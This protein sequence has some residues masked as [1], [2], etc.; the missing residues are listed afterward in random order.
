MGDMSNLAE[1]LQEQVW[2]VAEDVATWMVDDHDDVFEE[3]A[4]SVL[5][6]MYLYN[7][8]GELAELQLLISYGGPNI[9]M[10]L[11]P[12]GRCTVKGYWGGERAV[13]ICTHEPDLFDY[14]AAAAPHQP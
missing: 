13:A 6:A 14:F 12:D 1:Q 9:W 2:S 8:K 10:H 3:M 5:D 4:A 7:T 11:T